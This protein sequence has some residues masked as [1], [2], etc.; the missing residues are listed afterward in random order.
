MNN[1]DNGVLTEINKLRHSY[2]EKICRN[3]I[4]LRNNVINLADRS[5][6]SSRDIASG[7]VKVIGLPLC[8]DNPTPQTAGTRFSAITKDFLNDAFSLLHYLRPGKWNFAT[9]KNIS[10]FEQ[11]EHLALLDNIVKTSTELKTILGLDYIITSDIVVSRNNISTT[12]LDHQQQLNTETQDIAV[13]TPL[14]QKNIGDKKL[15]HAS[16]SCKLTI[17]SDRAQN[18]RT[19]ALNLI[20]NR[21]GHTPIIVAVTAEPLPMRVASLALGTGDLDCTYHFALPELLEAV[22]L[23]NNDDQMDMLNTLV[24]GRRLRDIADLPFDLAI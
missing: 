5:S 21:K 2:H 15:L 17:R 18:T 8:T 22:K 12:E 24:Q 13:L 6:R 14:L 10:E 1:P 4:F 7:L 19:E 16:I 3:V 9:E 23:I 11:Y 20:R